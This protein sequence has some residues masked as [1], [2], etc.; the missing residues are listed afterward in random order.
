[1]LPCFCQRSSRC[2]VGVR[3]QLALT[4]GPADKCHV[5]NVTKQ[6][7]SHGHSAGTAQSWHEHDGHRVLMLL[8]LEWM[9]GCPPLFGFSIMTMILIS[10]PFKPWNQLLQKQRGLYLHP[11]SSATRTLSSSWPRV[12]VGGGATK[13]PSFFF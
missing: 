6:Q 8:L 1:M 2:F 12:Y 10:N 9:N 7:C 4:D 13:Y 3:G 5:G 11:V